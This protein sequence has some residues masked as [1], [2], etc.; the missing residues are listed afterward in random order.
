M[1]IRPL[2]LGTAV[3]LLASACGSTV[4]G[5][6]GPA[7]STGGASSSS[8]VT[9]PHSSVGD[10]FTPGATNQDPA[11]KIQGIEIHDYATRDHVMTPQRVAYDQAPPFGGRHDAEWAACNGVTY[12][13]AVRTE[14]MVHALEHGAVWITYNPDKITGDDLAVLAAKVDGQPYSVMS[15]YPGLDHP[16]SLQSWGHRLKLDDPTDQRV[17][18]F[19]K[20]LRQN[21]YTYPEPGATCDNPSFDQDNPPPFDPSAPGPDAMPA[22]S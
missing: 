20:S 19:I 6:P 17:D 7:P 22:G 21:P 2:L 13:K 9:I 5:V 18:Q 1:R 14:H 12:K 8:K 16:V 10:D 15:P 3:A 11:K 4:P